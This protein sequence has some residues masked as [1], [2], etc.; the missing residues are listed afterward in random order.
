MT[1]H[2]VYCP[3][4]QTILEDAWSLDGCLI[5][6]CPECAFILDQKEEPDDGCE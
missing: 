5:L 2:I 4:C 3:D 6:K 1:I